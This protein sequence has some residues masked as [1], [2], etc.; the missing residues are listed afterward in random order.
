MAHTLI[1]GDIKSTHIDDRPEPDLT[2]YELTSGAKP[3]LFLFDT[4]EDETAYWI[5]TIPNMMTS[6][7]PAR[8][9]AILSHDYSSLRRWDDVQKLGVYVA[10][11][12]RMKGLEFKVVCIPTLNTILDAVDDEDELSHIRRKLFTA[13]TR[14][15][16]HL[17]LSAVQS[18]PKPFD[19]ILDFVSVQNVKNA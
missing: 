13:I 17:I 3:S 19:M 16:Q 14:A 2:S 12:Q 1:E 8:E 7:L 4:I 11:F 9:I 5:H 6:H 10:G 18:I 15:K